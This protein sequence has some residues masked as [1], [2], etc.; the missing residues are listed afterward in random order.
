[1]STAAVSIVIPVKNEA[2]N[3]ALCLESVQVFDD[4][5]VVDS[6]STDET[7]DI[8][9]RYNRPIVQ[10]VWDG[11]FPKKRNWILQ[12]HRFQ[13]PWVLFLDADERMTPDVRDEL[14]RVLP[15]TKHDAFWIGYRNWFLGRLLRYGDPMRK[16]ALLRVGHGAYEKILEEAW[17]GLDMEIHEHMVV[18]GSVGTIEAKLEHH[19]KRDMYAY[20][21]RHNDYSTWEAKRYFSLKDRSQLTRRQ[22]IKYRLLTWAC[23]PVL[24]FCASYIFKGGFLDG[25]AGFYFAVGKMFYFYQIQAKIHELRGDGRA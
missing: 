14:A 20:Y 21:S 13:H 19:D 5:V 24:Y 12:N 11:R 6:G 15:N 7:C 17:S 23:F 8:A 18:D 3:L 16:T 4:V 22:R 2:A 1:M 9:R 25:R 10:F